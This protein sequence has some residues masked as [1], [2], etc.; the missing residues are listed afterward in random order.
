MIR[1]SGLKGMGGIL[2]VRDNIIR[3]LLC[4]TKDEILMYLNAKKQNYCT[5]ETNEDD[6]YSRNAIRNN[7]IPALEAVQAES[8]AHIARTAEELREAEEYIEEAAKKIYKICVKE[9][10]GGY[11]I[12]LSLLK[13]EK[14][15]ILRN[16]I[17]Y[18]M[19]ELIYEWKDI[20]RIH[21][22]D[23]LSLKDKGRGKEIHLPKGLIAK[24]VTGGILIYKEAVL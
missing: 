4:V 9:K 18:T 12:D 13:D 2:P 14:P 24:K 5:D 3:P 23:V 16:I 11:F 19:Q 15:I 6:S 8:A 1:G 7:V 17:I 10:D 20:T 22:T 21:I